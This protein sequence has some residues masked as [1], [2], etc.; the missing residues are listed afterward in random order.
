MVSQHHY[1]H[2]CVGFHCFHSQIKYFVLQ[3]PSSNPHSLHSRERK[4]YFSYFREQTKIHPIMSVMHQI[5]CVAMNLVSPLKLEGDMVNI[6]NTQGHHQTEMEFFSLPCVS[7]SQFSFLAL[8]SISCFS[9]VCAA[10][11]KSKATFY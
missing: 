10:E 6:F 11:D 7:P 1:D 8:V 2:G 5:P 9:N 3:M 4:K